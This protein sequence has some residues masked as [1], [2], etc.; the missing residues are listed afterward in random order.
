MEIDKK[1]LDK[2][3]RL[4]ALHLEDKHK[5]DMLEYLKETLSHFKEIKDIPT[6]NIKPLVSPF[7]PTLCL[8]KDEV[9]QPENQEEFLQQAPERQSNFFKVPP[10][11]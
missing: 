5:A 7:S 3:A 6:E 8:R 9:I 11:V 2:L 4:S 1:L 10:V